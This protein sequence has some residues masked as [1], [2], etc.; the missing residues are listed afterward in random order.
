MFLASDS[1]SRDDKS[2][3][4]R[5][6]SKSRD[7]KV[8]KVVDIADVSG[9]KEE[10]SNNQNKFI[11]QLELDNDSQIKINDLI[12]DAY[13]KGTVEPTRILLFII[14]EGK[15]LTLNMEKLKSANIFESS[16]SIKKKAISVDQLILDIKDIDVKIS[17]SILSQIRYI[18]KNRK[19]KVLIS[20]EL[21]CFN[22]KKP[23]GIIV[24]QK[25]VKFYKVTFYTIYID[26]YQSDYCLNNNKK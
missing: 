23:N 25:G 8:R 12:C 11:K 7:D 21:I 20:K 1:R 4:Q 2:R 13:A 22:S 26:W 17:N 18:E 3:S 15:I 5:S 10:F 24:P 6:G 16:T 19:L 14:G 9:F